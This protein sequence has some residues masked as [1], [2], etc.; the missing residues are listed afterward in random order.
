MFKFC[1]IDH[2]RTQQSQPRHPYP[3]CREGTT[4]RRTL[5]GASA[6]ERLISRLPTL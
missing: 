2:A 5:S 6:G 1:R 3:L 4:P